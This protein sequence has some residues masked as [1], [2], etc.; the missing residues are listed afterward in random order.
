MNKRTRDLLGALH[1]TAASLRRRARWQLAGTVLSLLIG[2]ILA[3][4]GVSIATG[5]SNFAG[6]SPDYR[7]ELL[8]VYKDRIE[9]IRA[10]LGAGFPGM[11]KILNAEIEKLDGLK[12]EQLLDYSLSSLNSAIGSL[13]EEERKRVVAVLE[14]RYERISNDKLFNLTRE[15]VRKSLN[16]KV[17]FFS[18]INLSV[19]ILLVAMFVAV[20]LRNSYRYSTKLAGY[21]EAAASTLQIKLATTMTE[22]EFRDLT[23]PLMLQAISLEGSEADIVKTL[24]DFLTKPDSSQAAPA[25]GT[26]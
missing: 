23:N 7:D 11:Q 2:L 8:V 6:F 19:V 4:Q 22:Q 3:L 5:I 21:Y 25:N 9:E 20:L 13:P 15:R 17:D 14:Q 24:T 1:N 10:H 16:A 26:D 12:T 18:G